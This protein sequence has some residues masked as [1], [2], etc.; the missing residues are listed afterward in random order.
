M[1]NFWTN[2]WPLPF[3]YRP[4]KGKKK[5]YIF[6]KILSPFI[7]GGH[8]TQCLHTLRVKYLRNVNVFQV[9]KGKHELKQRICFRKLLIRCI[10]SDPFGLVWKNASTF[11]SAIIFLYSKFLPTLLHLLL[12]SILSLSRWQWVYWILHYLERWQILSLVVKKSI[13]AELQVECLH[14][15]KANPCSATT[16][17]QTWPLMKTGRL[18]IY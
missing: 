12:A 6:L 14:M 7:W 15:F 4:W 5:K 13:F 3:P 18:V 1:R 8:M 9:K 17:Q 10:L 16:D 11:Y 2:S